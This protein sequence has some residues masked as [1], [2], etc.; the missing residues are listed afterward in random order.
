M[1]PNCQRGADVMPPEPPGR[2]GRRARR[3]SI[4]AWRYWRAG[5]T[6]QCNRVGNIL[7]PARRDFLYP[8]GRRVLQRRLG[9]A[10]H[11]APVSSGLAASI[12][13][14]GCGEMPAAEQT[15]CRREAR[16]DASGQFSEIADL[17]FISTRCVEGNGGSAGVSIYSRR[18]GRYYQGLFFSHRSRKEAEGATSALD[19]IQIGAPVRGITVRMRLNCA[20]EGREGF[21]PGGAANNA[22]CE[23]I[24]IASSIEES[25]M[26]LSELS[27]YLLAKTSPAECG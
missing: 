21:R 5:S 1:R 24:P 17:A 16:S 9:R 18:L 12:A 2:L 7:Y 20:G 27:A 3:C 22:A 13:P 8:S 6:N 25:K 10:L 23:W 15:H 26:C 14:V 19:S 11:R 4:A